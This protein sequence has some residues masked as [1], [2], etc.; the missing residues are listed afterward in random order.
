MKMAPERQSAKSELLRMVLGGIAATAGQ[1]AVHPFDISKIRMQMSGELGAKTHN[2]RSI[3]HSIWLIYSNEGISSLYKGLCASM[4]REI[5]YSSLR[6]GLY[7]PIKQIFGEIDPSSTPFWKKLLSGATAG[8]VASSLCTPLDLVKVRCQ[9][10]ELKREKMV[11]H[12]L[13]LM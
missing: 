1:T 2:Y 11:W 13:E 3:L 9:A 4:I 7:E 6:V 12:A 10:W 5:I 8:T